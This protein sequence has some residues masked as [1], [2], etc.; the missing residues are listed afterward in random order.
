MS[1]TA[2]GSHPAE[3]ERQMPLLAVDIDGGL[4]RLRTR[5]QLR[6]VERLRRL[7]G[8]RFIAERGEWVLPARREGLAALAQLLAE[9]GDQAELSERARR[10]L[11]RHGPGR[12][13]VREGEFELS[14]RPRPQLVERIRTV[15]E[16]RWLTERRRW[17]VPTTRAGAL[18]LLTLVDDGEL[19]A[20]PAT[21]A[22][23]RRLAAGRAAPGVPEGGRAAGEPGASRASPRKHWR[24]VSRGPIFR[25]NPHRHEW[26]EGIGWCVRV[27]VDP[28]RPED[29]SER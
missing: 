8:R 23:L 20:A 3:A 15:P 13:E 25:A 22:R 18:A 1:G 5:Y 19:V 11:E 24:H 29:T 14:V 17:R 27:R 12:I 4:V 16:R 21:L 26:I 2:T 6:L 9:L 10:R 7:P 28:D